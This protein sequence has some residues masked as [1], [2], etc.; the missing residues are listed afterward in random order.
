MKIAVV[1][2]SG[3]LNHVYH[4]FGK[5]K[6]AR[7][8]IVVMCTKRPHRMLH[9][10]ILTTYRTLKCLNS[11]VVYQHLGKIHAYTV[12]PFISDDDFSVKLNGTENIFYNKLTNMM[13][14]KLNALFSYN[15]RTKAHS[16]KTKNGH[17]YTGKDYDAI[18][19]IFG[20]M[21]ASLN[22]IHIEDI[23]KSNETNPWVN[24]NIHV[25]RLGVKERIINEYNITVVIH[26]QPFLIDD[27]ITENTYPHTQ[28]DDC[29]IV[30]KGSELA[31]YEQLLSVFSKSGWIFNVCVCS[32]VDIHFYLQL[33]KNTLIFYLF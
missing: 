9:N 22:I 1:D 32:G 31:L 21:N 11:V 27:G 12:N 15:D 24:S 20:H 7:A 19:T 3:E 33:Y 14:Y 18:S 8:K 17:I 23:L 5:I 13:G 10:I 25:N 6:M 30:L 29:I 2:P 4:I 28:D 26:S 16:K